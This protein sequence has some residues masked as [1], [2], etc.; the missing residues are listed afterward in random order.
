MKILL[1]CLEYNLLSGS[2][3]YVYELTRELV[4]IGHEVGIISQFDEG[5]ELVKKSQEFGIEMFDFKSFRVNMFKPDVLHLMQPEPSKILLSVF[6]TTPAVATIHHEFTPFEQPITDPNIKKYIA[7]R[8]EIQNRIITETGSSKKN[9]EII[10]NPI[11][12]SRFNTEDTEQ[13]PEGARPK[14]LFVGT[15]DFLR[16]QAL[17]DLIAQAIKGYI[18]LYIVGN[19]NDR[20]LNFDL[21]E[22]VHWQPA[23]WDIEQYVKVCD[24]TAGILMGRS[25]IEGWACGKPGIIYDINSATQIESVDEHPVPFDM[26]RFD[27]RLVAQ[28]IIKVYESI[29]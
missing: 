14:V 25:T 29:L 24:K 27:S 17:F 15:I 18:D 8:P 21:P 5:S 20:Y 3:A 7:I 9:I 26:S 1:T 6:P 23:V 12:F 22:N 2:P 16:R 28:Q 13:S 19:K 4:K 10:Y 11:D